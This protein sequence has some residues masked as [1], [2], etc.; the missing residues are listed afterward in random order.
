LGWK[1]GYKSAL[2]PVGQVRGTYLDSPLLTDSE[3]QESSHPEVV[4]H[5]DT[6]TWTDLE[7]PLR[8]HDLGVDTRDLDTSIQA[9]SLLISKALTHKEWLLT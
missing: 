5:V 2:H 4:S 8:R 6:G 9:G 1:E 7:L 3:E